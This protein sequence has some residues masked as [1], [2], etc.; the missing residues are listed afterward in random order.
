[1]PGSPMSFPRRGVAEKQELAMER[2]EPCSLFN[3]HL[4][5]ITCYPWADSRSHGNEL[6]ILCCTV[7]PFIVTFYLRRWHYI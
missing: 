1:M 2:H 4:Q 5:H 6:S 3:E 7:N